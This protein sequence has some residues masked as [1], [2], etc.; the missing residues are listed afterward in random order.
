MELTITT[1]ALLFPTVSLVLL[2]YTN[3][4]LAVAALIR[5]LAA[6][7]K[8]DHNENV[9][10]QIKSLKLRVRLIRDMQMLS[11]F[12][13]LLS[14]VCMFSL[15]IGEIV[16]AKYVF[17]AS[18]LSLMISLGMSLREIMISTHALAIQLK[19]MGDDLKL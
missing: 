8:D 4:F 11:I 3:R 14:V 6:Q 5:K 13:L 2:A 1:P 12:A 9:A 15:F 10:D 17:S 19:D 18:L 16:L 7:Y